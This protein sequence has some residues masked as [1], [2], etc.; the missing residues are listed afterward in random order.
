MDDAYAKV[1]RR[2]VSS[3]SSE[4]QTLPAWN[5]NAAGIRAF[6]FRDPDLHPLEL[7]YFPPGKGDPKWHRATASLF[8]GIDHTAIAVKNTELS[9]SFYRDRLGFHVAGE[10]LNYGTEQEHLNNVSGS[11]VRITGL[12]ALSGPGIE[13]LEY[14]APSGGRPFPPETRPNDAWDSHTTLIVKDLQRALSSCQS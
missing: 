5:M 10:S 7:I 3:I 2:G 6:Y 9:I 8:L 4:P 14:L 13:L 11:R 1:A 12:R